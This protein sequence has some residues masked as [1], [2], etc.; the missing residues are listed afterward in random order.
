MY[1]RAVAA[2]FLA[3]LPL[4]L[5]ALGLHWRHAT[6]VASTEAEAH[7]VPCH[8]ARRPIARLPFTIDRPGSYYLRRSLTG[9]AGAHG[10]SVLADDVTIDLNGFTLRG[11]P[12]SKSGVWG[13]PGHENVTLT[14][15]VIRDWG[16]HG[17]ELS[18]ASACVFVDLRV[19]GNLGDGIRSGADSEALRCI[20]SENGGHPLLTHQYGL[21]LGANGQISQ[22]VA[23]DNRRAG[24]RVG[25]GGVVSGCTTDEHYGY[26]GVSAG[27]FSIVRDSTALGGAIYAGNDSSIVDCRAVGSSIGGISAGD[28][29][30]IRSCSVGNTNSTGIR[31]G[32]ES[33]IEDCVATGSQAT[34]ISAGARSTLR[35]CRTSGSFWYGISLGDGAVALRCSSE[36]DLVG[37]QGERACSVIQSKV[38]NSQSWGIW[39][40]D[41]SV[42]T[43]NL[44]RDCLDAGITVSGSG[45]RIESNQVVNNQ[46][47]GLAVAG[48]GNC[49][50]KNT[51]ADNS[52]DNYDIGA[53]N[54]HGSI[55]NVAAGG[56][57]TADAWA[58]LEF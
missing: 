13:A 50:F 18:L 20:V 11:V 51:A 12:S 55:M 31:A 38:S 7:D 41:G 22:C 25:S 57:F 53:G 39:V 17:V 2:L 56:S 6:R 8:D 15:G 34:G 23:S 52:P 14:N 32:R 44:V 35:D 49:V 58:N 33:T 30:V 9:V 5:F 16:E 42:V 1:M 45:S 37:I 28:R 3:G 10:V 26:T 4:P 29:S 43:G 21:S 36:G 19:A 47:F 40:L 24:I 54:A 48:T 46:Y 27:S